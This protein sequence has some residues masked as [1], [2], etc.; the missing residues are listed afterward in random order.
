MVS[1]VLDNSTAVD[2]LMGTDGNDVAAGLVRSHALDLIVPS[3]F[4]AEL[5]YVLGK[6]IYR[7]SIDRRFRDG[8]LARARQL[9]QVTDLETAT[10]SPSYDRALSLGDQYGLTIYD[11]VYLELAL[12]REARIITF[13]ND[14]ID[15]AR[16]AAVEVLTA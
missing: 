1:V 4:W 16:A 9:I 10:P 5:A 11:A 2:W 13:D 7:G 15:A 3:L 6:R 8:C 12:R 14:L